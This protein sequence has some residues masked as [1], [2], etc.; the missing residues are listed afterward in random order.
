[1]PILTARLGRA[2]G[3]LVSLCR[4]PHWGG[5]AVVD[6]RTA[7]IRAW[8]AKMVADE[9]GVP[10]IENAFWLPRR[11]ARCGVGR[12]RYTAQPV[13]GVRLLSVRTPTAGISAM[14]RWWGWLVLWSA[15]ARW[16]GFWPTPHDLRHT[17][18]SLAVSA[19]AT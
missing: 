14:L 15:R 3:E 4:V 6:V 13:R 17:A 11:G 18:A 10:T 8:L 19:G 16:C 5:V 2:V 12:Q 7:A 9:V 1:M